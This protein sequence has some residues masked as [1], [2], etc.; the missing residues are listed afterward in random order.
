MQTQEKCLLPDTGNSCIR[1]R[2][3]NG[4]YLSLLPC[5]CDENGNVVCVDLCEPNGNVLY[6]GVPIELVNVFV[7]KFGVEKIREFVLKG[8]E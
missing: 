6:C 2:G 1:L 3:K 4:N 7:E 8:C 5:G